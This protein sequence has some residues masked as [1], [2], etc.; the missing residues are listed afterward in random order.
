MEW[1]DLTLVAGLKDVLLSFAW[2][3]NV[4]GKPCWCDPAVYSSQYE[5]YPRCDAARVYFDEWE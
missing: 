4:D 3:N 1:D 2:K 5:H